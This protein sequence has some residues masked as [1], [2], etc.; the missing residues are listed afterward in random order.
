MAVMRLPDGGSYALD[1]FHVKGGQDHLISY[2]ALPGPVETGGLNLAAQA[3]GSYAGA[4][5]PYG[6]SLKGR[7]MG[8]SWL[9][10]VERDT[11]PPDAFTLDVK[12]TPPF[13]NLDASDDAHVRYHALNE[14][15]DVA[16]AD[17]VPPGERPPAIRYFLG[18]RAL[19]ATDR[20]A[21]GLAST[22]VSIVEPY[23]SH[24][25]IR[26][27]TRL[28]V[29]GGPD[30]LEAAVLRVDLQDGATDYLMVSPDDTTTFR[31]PG[32]IEFR[33]RMAA[34]R[35]R[36]D[37]VEQAWLAR[38]SRLVWGDLRIDLPDVGLRGRIVKMDRGLVERG[39]VWVDTD[40][41][42]DG[43]L[44]GSEIIIENDGELNASY[45]I[46]GVQE[47]DGRYRVDCGNVCF[48]RAFTDPMD[49]GKG[50]VYN[51]E[52]GGAW[53]IPNRLHVDRR[54]GSP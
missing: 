42:T 22:F 49:Y 44:I 11:D 6:T 13:P 4:D 47:H 36:G 39:H 26:E 45:T 16:L 14:Y 19:D 17:G 21:G 51:F 9:K 20:D 38:A 35:T 33:G 48:V 12:G 27:A 46:H 28:P 3:G 40:L 23:R 52:E 34:V 24:P 7:R 10:D 54:V 5:V 31:T 41:P 25:H 15:T 37:T 29:S 53:V 8:Y 30:G 50:Y 18:R 1:V 2:H 43:S 32:G